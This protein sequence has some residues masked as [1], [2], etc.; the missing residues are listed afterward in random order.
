MP[1]CTCLQSLAFIL[2]T[3]EEVYQSF[4]RQ[5][6]D[7]AIV[8]GLLGGLDANLKQVGIP[9]AASRHIQQWYTHWWFGARCA[10]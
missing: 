7:Q 8:S 5:G 9:A 6:H 4:A 3:K 1:P 2:G 10:N